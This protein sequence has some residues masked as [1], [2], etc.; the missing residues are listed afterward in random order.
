M[1]DAFGV[2]AVPKDLLLEV[3]PGF[4]GLL[5]SGG[6][7]FFAVTVITLTGLCHDLLQQCVEVIVC[8][9]YLSAFIFC[10]SA[11]R[12]LFPLLLY[13]PVPF[14]QRDMCRHPFVVVSPA[15]LDRPLAVCGFVRELHPTALAP[16]L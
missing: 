13:Q 6:R 2:E 7:S 15:L 14:R 16:L 10:T 3:F 4:A 9:D 8:V 1:S 11:G 5:V 12:L